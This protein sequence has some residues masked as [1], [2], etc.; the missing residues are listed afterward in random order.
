MMAVVTREQQLVR[1]MLHWLSALTVSTKEAE[2]A[3]SCGVELWMRALLCVN[4][5]VPAAMLTQ[6][7]VTISSVEQ[8]QIW[9]HCST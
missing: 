5:V 7:V 9:T 3:R 4:C 6:H 8:W 1:A 2:H